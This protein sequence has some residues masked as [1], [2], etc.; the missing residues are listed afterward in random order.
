[1]PTVQ[2]NNITMHYEEAGQG[3][4]L[5]LLHGLGSSAE[6][7]EL[8]MPAFAQRYRVIVPDARGHGRTDK[9]PGPYSVPQ[10]AADARGLLDVLGVASAHIVGL[11]MGGMIA[12]QMAVDGP[13]RVRSLVIVNS[14]PALVPRTFNEWLRV[15]QRLLLARLFSP[16]RSARFLSRRLFPRPEQEE[17]RVQLIERWGRNDPAAYRAAMRALVGWSVLDRVRDIRCPVLVIAGDR[18]YTPV[19]AKRAYADLIPGA[20][21]VVFEDSGH[22]TPIDQAERFNEVVLGFL[23]GG[24]G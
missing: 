13:E 23:E 5:L 9:P 12:F 20:R 10:M 1:M 8:Q 18:D 4:P 3:E 15:R 6:D 19:E 2:T 22:A 24:V 16:A 14:G 21:L 11:S 7:W 17:A